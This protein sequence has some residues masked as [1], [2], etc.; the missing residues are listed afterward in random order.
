MKLCILLC[1]L[2]GSALASAAP[3]RLAIIDTGYDATLAE[4]K[5]KLCKDGHF[6]FSNGKA[7]V[8][9]TGLHGTIVASVIARGLTN[10]DYCAVIITLEMG[11]GFRA[12]VISEAVEKLE[13]QNIKAVNMSL[14]GFDYSWVEYRRLRILTMQG[15]AVFAASG[16]ENLDL[17][18]KCNVYPAC[19]QLPKL[20]A[21][22][23]TD[24]DPTLK[25]P[26]TNYGSKVILWFPGDTVFQGKLFRGTSF[27]APA[28]TSEFIRAL[29]RIRQQQ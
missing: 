2:V 11:A 6:N 7:E 3:I 1:L 26:Y 21:V 15:T 27:A 13:N 9:F 17:D 19:Y 24:E 10:V 22:G 5:I 20:Y 25:A 23:A 12:D 4:P 16:N 18:Q 29:Y 28:A 14:R 8:G